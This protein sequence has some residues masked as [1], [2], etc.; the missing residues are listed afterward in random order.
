LFRCTGDDEHQSAGQ[1]ESDA[2]SSDF[3]DR[4][5]LKE[6]A[7]S[8]SEGSSENGVEQDLDGTESDSGISADGLLNVSLY[9]IPVCDSLTAAVLKFKFHG[10]R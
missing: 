6:E 7:Q 9:F 3:E 2:G 4:S 5:S 10:W 8:Q 1:R